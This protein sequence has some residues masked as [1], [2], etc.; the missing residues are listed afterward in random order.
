MSYH[1]APMVGT[2]SCDQTESLWLGGVNSRKYCLASLIAMPIA[3]DPVY[4]L[5][6]INLKIIDL[7]IVDDET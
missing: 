1:N 5:A 4:V 3:S 6:Q 7:T 2:I